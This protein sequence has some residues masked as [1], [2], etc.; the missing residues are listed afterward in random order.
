[1]FRRYVQAGIVTAVF[2]MAGPAA[3]QEGP[4]AADGGLA[5]LR[6]SDIEGAIDRH[7]ALRLA[8]SNAERADA[9]VRAERQMPNPE[10][11]ASVGRA[12]SLDGRESG[13]I[14]GI[15]LAIP[16]ERLGS[17]HWASRS[18]GSEAEAARLDADVQRLEVTRQLKTMFMTAVI[19]QE[20]VALAEDSLKR[21]DDLLAVATAREQ[22][23]EGRRLDVIRLHTEREKAA[24]A[25]FQAR[26]VLSETL[27]NLDRVLG[28][29]LHGQFTVAA[30]WKNLAMPDS[31]ETCVAGLNSQHPSIVAAS[32]RVVA[33]RDAIRAEQA[34]NIPDFQVGGFY[35]L[36]LDA[37]NYGAT[38]SM[39]L[40][41][42]N[43]NRGR[44]EASR[45]MEQAAQ[46]QMELDELELSRVVT[47]TYA[48]TERAIDLARRYE[49]SIL[50]DAVAA[51]GMARELY[52]SGETG[53][54]DVLDAEQTAIEIHT[55]MLNAFLDGWT[56]MTDLGALCGGE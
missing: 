55:E 40:P 43:H 7:P 46:N 49:S 10:L 9:A 6:W 2:I 18:A 12:D 13:V 5:V 1:M 4:G 44:I 31:P 19:N 16:L 17:M 41:I 35:E 36:E 56:Q 21:A 27:Q 52:R 20:L 51:A 33:A 24:G 45:A 32:R 28:G 39:T 42:W 38:L 48:R 3:A 54:I 50:P 29:R 23:G 22:A 53:L 11:S 8:H 25:L 14:W 26:S 37:N 34:G 47:S 30:D 15:E